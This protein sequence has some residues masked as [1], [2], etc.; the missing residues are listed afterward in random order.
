ML[1]YSYSP[2]F[3]TGYK[4]LSRGSDYMLTEFSDRMQG[5][6]QTSQNWCCFRQQFILLA[7]NL[8]FSAIYFNRIFIEIILVNFLAAFSYIITLRHKYEN[9]VDKMKVG[10]QPK[11]SH[12]LTYHRP[13]AAFIHVNG[14]INISE[15]YHTK[16]SNLVK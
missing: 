3:M 14:Q 9:F 1:N 6:V 2:F 16:I 10:I 7:D 13:N 5:N 12:Y 15:K 4:I 8:F 11:N